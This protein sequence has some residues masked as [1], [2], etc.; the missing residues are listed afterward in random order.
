MIVEGENYVVSVDLCVDI[1]GFLWILC[2]FV[3]ILRGFCA[4]L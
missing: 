4:D 1:C 2:G 3:W